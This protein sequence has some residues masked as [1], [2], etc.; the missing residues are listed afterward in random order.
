MYQ[1]VE[2]TMYHVIQ[3]AMSYRIISGSASWK[4]II[5]ADGKKKPLYHKLL[6]SSPESNDKIKKILLSRSPGLAV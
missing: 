1:N 6:I 2:C 3:Y 5:K 4:C